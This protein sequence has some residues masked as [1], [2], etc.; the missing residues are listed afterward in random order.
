MFP[1]GGSACGRRHFISL[2]LT[3]EDTGGIGVVTRFPSDTLPDRFAIVPS[4]LS[5]HTCLSGVGLAT[6]ETRFENQFLVPA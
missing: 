1:Q 4:R 2:P 3:V 6:S 5:N